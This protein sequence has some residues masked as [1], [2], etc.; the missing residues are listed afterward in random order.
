[1]PKLHFKIITPDKIVFD[2]E[3]ESLTLPTTE[4]EITILP[5][6]IPLI[7]AIKPGEIMIK[8]EGKT[9]HMAVMGGFLEIS[10]NKIS[11]MA[12]AAELAEEIDERRADEAKERAKKAVS[13]AKDQIEFADATAALERSLSRIKVAHRK[14]R[15]HQ[16]SM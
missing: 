6:H 11:L 2:Q 14:S 8:Q 12:E 3:I 5:N 15:H 16:S 9:H 4:G 13:E 1:M 7:T 10:D